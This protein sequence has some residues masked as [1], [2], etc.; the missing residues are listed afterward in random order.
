MG[1]MYR[2][3]RFDQVTNPA[4][5]TAFVNEVL[6]GERQLWW[7]S[8]KLK[9]VKYSQ[10]IVGND[11]EA[12]VFDSTKDSLVLMYHPIASK[13]RGVK[14]KFEEFAK[15]AKVEGVQI[16]RYNGVNESPVYRCPSKLPALVY[17]RQ[18]ADGTFKEGIEF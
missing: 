5:L 13:N 9:K 15:T 10:K 1:K 7:A 11:F 12:R 17:F 2:E 8:E 14:Q 18:S 4:K 6:N 16:G 3:D